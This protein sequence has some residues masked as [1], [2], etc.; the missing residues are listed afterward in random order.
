MPVSLLTK[1]GII[2][3]FVFVASFVLDLVLDLTGE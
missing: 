3:A 1:I 2:A